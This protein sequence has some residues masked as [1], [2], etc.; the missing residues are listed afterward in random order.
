[1]LMRGCLLVLCCVRSVSNCTSFVHLL[2]L[3]ALL[4]FLL[5]A[6]FVKGH[7]GNEEGRGYVESPSVG[8]QSK[9]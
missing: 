5:C 1:M 7:W 6:G 8:E 2:S 9:K 3:C 4:Y